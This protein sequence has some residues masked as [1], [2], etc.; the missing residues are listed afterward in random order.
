[1]RLTLL[2]LSVSVLLANLLPLFTLVRGLFDG[3]LT[4]SLVDRDFVNYWMGSKLALG[5]EQADLFFLDQYSIRLEEAFGPQSQIRAW[6]YPPHILLPL[7]PLALVPYEMALAL[8]LLSTGAL[9]F[10]GAEAL[11]KAEVPDADRLVV[12][13][14]IGAYATVNTIAGQNG[15]LTGALLLFGLAL[16]GK[17]PVLAGLAFGLLTI[18]PQ[19]GILV[20]LLLMVERDWATILWSGVFTLALVALSAF[21]FGTGVWHAYLAVTLVEQRSVL[22]DWSG[23]FLNMMPTVFGSVRSLGADPS[24]AAMAQWP[25]SIAAGVVVIWLFVKDRS[26][27]GRTFALLCATLLEIGRAHV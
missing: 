4:P 25:E 2:T 12:L 26:R 23:V 8:F 22:T 19:L 20:P 1:M 27:L 9:F 15:F 24:F 5:G 21:M 17:R 14:A 16:R 7:L 11:R 10:A 3:G 6:S 18:K 13:A